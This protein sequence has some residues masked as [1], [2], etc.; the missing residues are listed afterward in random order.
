[1]FQSELDQFVVEHAS[2]LIRK[3]ATRDVTTAIVNSKLSEAQYLND[4]LL[5]NLKNQLMRIMEKHMEY[6]GK[7]VLN[8][9]TLAYL[10]QVQHIEEVI[11]DLPDGE[12][13]YT[14]Q[15]R[16]TGVNNEITQEQKDE[17]L[18]EAKITVD[19]KL[20]EAYKETKTHLM[21]NYEKYI[22][23]ILE[24]PKKSF[25][26]SELMLSNELLDEIAENILFSRRLLQQLTEVTPEEFSTL[27]LQSLQ[28]DNQKSSLYEPMVRSINFDTPYM[29]SSG[30]PPVSQSLL[31]LAGASQ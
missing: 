28:D 25:K 6:L 24:N 29:M 13:G 31:A 15:V 21:R 5:R 3:S 20:F 14:K 16:I 22:I 26:D 1:M 11:D 30:M 27:N 4:K 10:D 2:Q 19:T 9:L 7:K 23:E 8:H 18:M 12:G 17:L